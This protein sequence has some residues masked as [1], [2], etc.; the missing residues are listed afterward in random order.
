MSS[1]PAD[2]PNEVG[3]LLAR[4]ELIAAVKVLRQHTNMDLAEAKAAVERAMRGGAG[5]GRGGAE[6][7]TA[8]LPEEVRVLAGRGEHVAAIRRLREL[9]GIGLKDARLA[10]EAEFGRLR[11]VP[12]AAVV[13]IVAIAAA[14]AWLVFA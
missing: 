10:V 12:K 5:A 7:A 2:V 1:S 8:A 6:P 9:R 13:A 4:G 3:E 11:L 14:V